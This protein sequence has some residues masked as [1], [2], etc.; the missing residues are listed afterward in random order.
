MRT[1]A[2]ALS[3][4]SADSCI[5]APSVGASVTAG[6]FRPSLPD[7]KYAHLPWPA[8]GSSVLRD[9]KLLGSHRQCE[10]CPPPSWNSLL[11]SSDV[12]R[13]H[14]G[15]M[16]L[17]CGAA[18]ERNGWKFK[19]LASFWDATF[20]ESDSLKYIHPL[21]FLILYPFYIRTTQPN[22]L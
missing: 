13:E 18:G 5:K 10:P 16:V 17:R 21:F 11:S 6:P 2:P 8:L 7:A 9:P 20:W 4:F 22:M 3:M 1:P 15:T 19:A 12:D 14:I